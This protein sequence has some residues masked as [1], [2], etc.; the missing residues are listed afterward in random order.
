MRPFAAAKNLTQGAQASVRADSLLDIDD[1]FEQ[2][3][4][5]PKTGWYTSI[6][7]YAVGGIPVVLLHLIDPLAYNSAFLVLGGLAIA[8][9]LISVLGLRH[10][11]NSRGATHMRLAF[12][13]GLMLVGAFSVGDA[14][15]AFL[16]IPLTVL[17][18]PAIY[19][20]LRAAVSYL[21][22]FAPFA[23]LA[24]IGIDQPWAPALA[25]CSVVT[26]VTIAV[27]MMVAQAHTRALARH[28]RTLAF[29]DALTGLANTRALNRAIDK[30]LKDP[31][32]PQPVL[33]AIDLDDFKQVNDLFD[34]ACGDEVLQTIAEAL[35]ACGKPGDLFAR[36]G[37]DEFSLLVS[38]PGDRDLDQLSSRLSD[39]IAEVRKRVCPEVS[40]SGS[41]AYVSA[42]PG[43]TV[44]SILRRA[45]DALHEAKVESHRH[46]GANR[47]VRL[48]II[49]RRRE[50]DR[51]QTEKI[52]V[53]DRPRRRAGD[54][55]QEPRPGRLDGSVSRDRPLW[56]FAATM[57][58]VI[59]LSIAVVASLGYTQPLGPVAGVAVGSGFLLLAAACLLACSHPLPASGIH[60]AFVLSLVLLSYA[61]AAAGAAGATLIDFYAVIA[62][63]AFHFFKP[64]VAARYLPVCIAI[65]AGFAIDGS[66]PYTGARVVAFAT[67]V[68]AAAVL[69]AKVRQ[70]TTRFIAD[71]W[72]LSRIDVL[73]AVYRWPIAVQDDPATGTPRVTP[74]RPRSPLP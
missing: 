11:P 12:G 73:E 64:A 2:I 51:A 26:V 19:F 20:G 3:G 54:A 43:D 7:L 31:E 23:T 45:D 49:D 37:G 34:H 65:F 25:L 32:K 33:F 8:M 56:R 10:F 57:N 21:I 1:R 48:A 24:A 74:L 38:D 14:R 62:I 16:L 59:G 5:T 13:I 9:S 36:R 15:Q 60:Y 52:S 72:W 69:T 66:Y 41:V 50:S 42:L 53:N 70:V 67:T 28:Q 61:V 6:A 55:V 17:L 63:F 22:V 30:Q 47:P 27:S 46:D 58:V 44:G 4:L 68:L 35:D 18:P 39:A 71:N 40:P 29:T